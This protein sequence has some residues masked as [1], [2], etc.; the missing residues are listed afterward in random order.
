MS[1]REE[2][3]KEYQYYEGKL[4][5]LEERNRAPQKLRSLFGE[6]KNGLVQ[7]HPDLAK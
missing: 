6:Y 1:P 2:L 3:E 4:K 5:E 7:K